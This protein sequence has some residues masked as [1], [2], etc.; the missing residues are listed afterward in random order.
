M[1]SFSLITLIIITLFMVLP[2]KAEENYLTNI[3]PGQTSTKFEPGALIRLQ[4]GRY[5]IIEK[6]LINGDLQTNLGIVISPEGL[7]RN[8]PQNGTVTLISPEMTQEEASPE[9]TQSAKSPAPEESVALSTPAQTVINET[10][11]PSAKPA[12][13]DEVIAP[14]LQPKQTPILE[15]ADQSTMPN[16]S[17]TPEKQAQPQAAQKHLTIAEMIPL[18]AAKQPQKPENQQPKP[19]PTASPKQEEKKPLP[20]KQ[21]TQ[22]AKQKTAKP[23]PGQELRIPPE[24]VKTGNL[25]F[26]EGCWQGTRPEYYSKRSIR[27]CFCFGSAGKNGKR[28]VVDPLGHRTCIG[29]TSAKL[30]KNGILSVT[31]QGAACDDGE[32]WGSA[33]MIC[34]NSGPKTPCSWV[35]RDA[36]NGRQSYTIPF[37]RV[38]SCGR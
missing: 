7:I 22:P 19:A 35:F 23:R 26:L 14:S 17:E 30:S 29:A 10:S 37:V 2:S 32:R 38:E 1:K 15:K 33:E 6:Y 11:S 25:D 8:D 18:T 28:H 4:D 36:N 3:Q 27:E 34:Q 12:M 21:K 31:S 13:P 24:A 16:A 5:A 9:L 20:E